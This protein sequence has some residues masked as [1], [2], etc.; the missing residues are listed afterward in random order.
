MPP[1][2]SP[3]ALL[4]V[5]GFLCCSSSCS[6]PPQS[7]KSDTKESGSWAPG[8]GTERP[9]G[10]PALSC[11]EAQDGEARRAGHRGG[12]GAFS[13]NLFFFRLMSFDSPTPQK[14]RLFPR[15]RHQLFPLP[16][17]LLAITRGD[18][19]P[20]ALPAP[21]PRGSGWSGTSRPTGST[22]VQGTGCWGGEEGHSSPPLL[23]SAPSAS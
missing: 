17:L 11:Q 18:L 1:R 8:L 14:S 23:G 13:T 7:P 12:A 20:S 3:Q 5:F 6:P 9:A 15:L 16:S 19:T 10:S 21:A 4:R 2:P 22:S